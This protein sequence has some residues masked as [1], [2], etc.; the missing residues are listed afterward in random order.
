[1]SRLARAWRAVS[2]YVTAVMGDQ[3]YA[4]HVAHLR[5][6]DPGARVPT[7]GEYWRARYAS[8]DANPGSRCC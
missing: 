8:Q 1:M 4:R 3:D 6:T 7:V 2:S 5:R